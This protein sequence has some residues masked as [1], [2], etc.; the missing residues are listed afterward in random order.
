MNLVFLGAPG[1]GKGTQAKRVNERYGLSH[2]STGDILRAEIKAGSDLGLAAK[3]VMDSGGLV[4]DDVIIGLGKGLDAVSKAQVQ[5]TAD[6]DRVCGLMRFRLGRLEQLPYL[7]I[8]SVLQA[9]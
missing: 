5:I 7:P 8:R 3:K 2:I 1:S 6:L 4:S 9:A